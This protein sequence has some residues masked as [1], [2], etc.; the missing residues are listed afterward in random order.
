MTAEQFIAQNGGAI[1]GSTPITP[2]TGSPLNPMTAPTQ[3]ATDDD[4]DKGEEIPSAWFKFENVGDMIKGTLVGKTYK[5]SDNPIYADQWVY[6]LNIGGGQVTKVPMPTTRSFVNDKMKYVS[7]GQIVAFKFTKEVP[8]EKFK[9]KFAKSI[10]VRVYGFDQTYRDD[11][12]IEVPME[13]F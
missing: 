3:P 5:K 6:E 4:W 10:D 9:G 7:I 1:V 8:S 13:A 2:D 11:S 12:E